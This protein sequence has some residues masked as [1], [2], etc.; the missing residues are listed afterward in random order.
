MGDIFSAIKTFFAGKKTH[1]LVLLAIV[2]ATFQNVVNEG[3]DL[4]DLRMWI[5]NAK[6]A[7]IS[8]FKMM[9]DR[10]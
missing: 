10:R 4:G 3:G 7:M 8:T 1:A 9:F 2:A 5:D 6:L